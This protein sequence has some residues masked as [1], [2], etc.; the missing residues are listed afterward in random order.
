MAVLL[1]NDFTNVP[2]LRRVSSVNPPT[3]APSTVAS[4]LYEFD[5]KITG[6]EPGLRDYTPLGVKT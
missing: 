1:G 2:I 4:T 3:P 6:V 5:S